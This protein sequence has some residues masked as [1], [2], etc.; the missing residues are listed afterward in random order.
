[1]RRRIVALS[2]GMTFLVVLSFAVP[3][4]LLVRQNVESKH[5]DEARF[6]ADNAAYFISSQDPDGDHVAAYL[7]GSRD[8]YAGTTWVVLADGTVVGQPPGGVPATVNDGPDDDGDEDDRPGGVSPADIVHRDDGAVTRVRAYGRDG[9]AD[10]YVY[11][12]DEQL[13]S[14]QAGPLLL[15]GG[16]SL[17]LLALS[18]GAAEAV[19]RRL[20]R[21]LEQTA[22]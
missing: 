12:T 14:G 13:N 21:P 18:F 8:R 2:V 15:L 6:Q 3:I 5:L 11:L 19:S 4:A 1:M 22:A 20:A 10:V 7:D 16:M 17:L 9:P